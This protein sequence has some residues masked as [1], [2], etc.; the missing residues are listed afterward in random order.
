ML[1]LHL[2]KD[3][4][5][6]ELMRL[7]YF[8]KMNSLFVIQTQKSTQKYNKQAKLLLKFYGYKVLLSKILKNR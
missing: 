1:L 3:L 2:P 6:F 4:S 7:F 8:H 5:L